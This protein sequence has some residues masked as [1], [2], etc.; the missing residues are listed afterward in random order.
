MI[1]VVAMFSKARSAA[2]LAAGLCMSLAVAGCAIQPLRPF[3]HGA[4]PSAVDGSFLLRDGTRLPYHDWHANGWLGQPPAT[5]VL[6]LHGF[7]DSRDAWEIPAPAFQDAGVELIAPDLP[8]FGDAPDRG[9]WPGVATMVDDT[10]QMAEQLRA[11]FP[12]ARL[13][14]MGESMGG[15]V[16]MAL[17]A[18]PDPPPVDGYVLVAPAV[19]SRAEMGLLL[20]SGLWL[21]S[22]V[23]PG[24]EVTGAEVP[25]RVRASDNRAAIVRLGQDPLTILA[26]RFDTLRGLVNLMDAA[27]AAA[28]DDTAP[29]LFLYGGHDDLVPPKATADMWRRLPP[30]AREAFYPNAYHLML[31]DL[32][33]AVPTGDIIAW[34]RNP[35]APL[36]SGAEAAARAWLARQP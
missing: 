10:R 13:V 4:P 11:R 28:P 9:H 7:N 18:A 14:L 20:R 21:A 35:S 27:S 31:R 23:V 3:P 17:A 33:R 2:R 32:D 8:G 22:H 25:V 24:M 30:T 34:L 26:T 36:P 5:V 12:H 29:M 1:A 15:A 16:L 19:W 6:A